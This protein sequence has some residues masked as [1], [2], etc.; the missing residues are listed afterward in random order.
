MEYVAW[1]KIQ[2][3]LTTI[4]TIRVYPTAHKPDIP[5]QKHILLPREASPLSIHRQITNP[6]TPQDY[7][8]V[9]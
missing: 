6:H 2:M 8:K 1:E 7:K 5:H 9:I 4:I 3:Q